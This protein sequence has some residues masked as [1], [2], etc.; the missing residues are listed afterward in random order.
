MHIEQGGVLDA[1]RIDIGV[2]EGIVGNGRWDITVDGVANHAGTTPMNQRHDALLAAARIVDAVNRVVTGMPGRQVGTV[3]RIEAVPGA[4]NV[5]PGEVILGLD[6]RDLD[7]A[8]IDLLY[9]RIVAEAQ[10]IANATGTT[11]QFKEVTMDLPAPR[12]PASGSSS[13]RRRGGWA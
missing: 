2:V 11:V 13:R 9:Q 7:A 10:L 3:G 5:I 4:Y 12:T 6:L 1:E 8:R